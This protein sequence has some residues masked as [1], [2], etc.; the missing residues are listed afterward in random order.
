MIT[1]KLYAQFINF[2]KT[3]IKRD[4][5]EEFLKW[6]DN[7]D[8]SVAPAST[9]YHGSMP[10]GL[11]KHSINVFYRL[12]K[13][14]NLEYPNGEECPYSKET[15]ALVSL[16]HD[17]SKVDFYE[18]STRNVKNQETGE[19]EHVKFYSTRPENK[20]F[21]FA[22]HEENSLYILQQ[23]FKLSYDEAM[24]IR[25]HGGAFSSNDYRN[26]GESLNAFRHSKL[27]LL[28]H[29]ADLMA[30]TVDELDETSTNVDY[31]N[32]CVEESV[33]QSTEESNSETEELPF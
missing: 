19:W 26:T 32:R 24:A 1:D 14:V 7:T 28:L 20:R 2:L 23:F 5:I 10:G 16:L 18:E 8:I 11:I 12:I 3:F 17:I 15:I 6:L 21:I 31:F 29:I 4:G 30:T 9:K 25:W 22:Y 13:L 33:E 27:A